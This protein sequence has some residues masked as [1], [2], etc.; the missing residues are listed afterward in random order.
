MLSTSQL[1][2]ILLAV[3]GLL[4]LVSY[5]LGRRQ[6]RRRADAFIAAFNQSTFGS[7]RI[8]P[9]LQAEQ[10]R[11]NGFAA[12][13]IPAPEPFRQLLIAFEPRS[14]LS[15]TT[16]LGR[17]R[18]PREY[19]RLLFI[20]KLQD[21]PRSEFVWGKDERIGR[22][23]TVGNRPR[24]WRRKHF[25]VAESEYV[26]RGPN[27]PTLEN[28]FHTLYARFGPLL[29]RVHVEQLVDVELPTV[30]TSDSVHLYVLLNSAKL[31]PQEIPALIAEILA[32]GRATL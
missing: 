20:G 6:D 16:W 15:I 11:T 21:T 12:W 23:L 18:H 29:Q 22:A 28:I 9:H 27:A 2:L 8:D 4:I 31:A 5:L 32:L 10:V 13:L 17:L 3:L 1:L 25:D 26:M 7:L 14:A 19:D 30:Q 24:L